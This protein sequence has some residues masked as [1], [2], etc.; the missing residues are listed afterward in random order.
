M[1]IWSKP[2]YKPYFKAGIE[3]KVDREVHFNVKK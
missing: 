2:T 3:K 1:F